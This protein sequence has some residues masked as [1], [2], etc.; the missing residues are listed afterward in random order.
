MEKTDHVFIAGYEPLRK[1]ATAVG[2][3]L[4]NLEP[5]KARTKQYQEYLKKMK[6][7]ELQEWPKNSSLLSN[8][9]NGMDTIGAAA[10]D[11]D[12][13]VCAGVSTGGR[14]MKLPGR[15]GDAPLPGAGL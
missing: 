13:V 11:A 9:Y 5:T 10:I 15:V 3:D 1:F 12:G 4:K 14:F 7:G 2:F 8:Y 6:A